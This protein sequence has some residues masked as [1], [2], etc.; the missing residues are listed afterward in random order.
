MDTQRSASRAMHRPCL[1]VLLWGAL[2]RTAP[3]YLAFVTGPNTASAMSRVMAR[4]AAGVCCAQAAAQSTMGPDAVLA[5]GLHRRTQVTP[6]D[7]SMDAARFDSVAR[8]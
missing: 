7:C 8:S 6:E 3:G 1:A 4:G 2:M 5:P